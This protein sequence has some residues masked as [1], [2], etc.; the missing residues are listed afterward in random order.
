M[1]NEPY[2][3]PILVFR[4]REKF[5]YAM[6]IIAFAALA[7]RAYVV[8]RGTENVT[9]TNLV[10]IARTPQ[11]LTKLQHHSEKINLMI[12]DIE[13]LPLKDIKSTIVE[14][15]DLINLTSKEIEAQYAAWINLKNKM[16]NDGLTFVEL[17]NKLETVQILQK[18][19]IENLKGVM[20]D[21]YEQSLLSQITALFIS[22]IIGVFSSIAASF[23]FPK[24]KLKLLKVIR[25]N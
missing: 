24:L 1:E 4:K 2:E 5:F 23:L 6:I 22:F 11:S 13:S 21:I 14:T 20:N 18:Q 16:D 25:K 9:K 15:V 19:E 7:Y 12:N 17:K 8:T 3:K 10:M